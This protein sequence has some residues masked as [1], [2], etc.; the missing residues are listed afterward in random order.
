MPA[1]LVVQDLWKSYAAGV[2]GCSARIWV[3]RGCTIEIAEGERVAVLGERGS[4]KTTLIRCVAGLLRADHGTITARPGLRLVDGAAL[5]AVGAA[6]TLL[7]TARR[8]DELRG[9]VD[10]L[11][12]LH[13]GRLVA[14]DRTRRRRVAEPDGRALR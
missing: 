13:D 9:P 4:G 10:R 7:V 12:R 11:L 8:E 1:A 3:L 5:A 2:R 6:P 14:A